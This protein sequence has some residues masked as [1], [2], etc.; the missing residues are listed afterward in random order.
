M[1]SIQSLNM[2]KALGHNNI[3]PLFLKTARNIVAPFLQVFIDFSFKNGIFPD[4]CKNRENFPLAL[5]RRR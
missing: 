2:N 1:K 5:K 4:N 3:S